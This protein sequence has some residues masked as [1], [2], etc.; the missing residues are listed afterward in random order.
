MN[1]AKHFTRGNEMIDP[2][3]LQ[4]YTLAAWCRGYA[5]GLD[6]FEYAALIH[7]LN[8]VSELLDAVWDEYAR[9]AGYKNAAD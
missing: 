9:E 2:T 6:K 1:A 3:K 4:Y 8:K 5:S 7:K